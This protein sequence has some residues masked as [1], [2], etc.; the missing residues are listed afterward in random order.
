MYVRTV[1]SRPDQKGIKN[2]STCLI[3]ILFWSRHVF[4]GACLFW[5]TH[6]AV[7]VQPPKTILPEMSKTTKATFSSSDDVDWELQHF[8][9]T[10]V[11]LCWKVKIQYISWIKR[12]TYDSLKMLITSKWTHTKFTSFHS[13]NHT[14]CFLCMGQDVQRCLFLLSNFHKLNLK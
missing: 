3:L 12:G 1:P 6:P 7:Q 10:T 9:A 4:Y 11:K 5:R 14:A 13:V 8:T 2:E